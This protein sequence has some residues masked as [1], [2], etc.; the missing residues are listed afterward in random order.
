L[1]KDSILYPDTYNEVSTE[2]IPIISSNSELFQGILDIG[3]SVG[4]FV[5]KIEFTAKNPNN[6]TIFLVAYG[7][8]YYS[9]YVILISMDQ[10]PY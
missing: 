3:L 9:G 6:D 10:V 4:D 2:W 1:I 5:I 7:V 8:E